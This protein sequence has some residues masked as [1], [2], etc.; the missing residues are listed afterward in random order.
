M[1]GKNP[2]L[3]D[4]DNGNLKMQTDFRQVYAAL[5]TD[6]L[7]ADSTAEA[8]TLFRDFPEAPIFRSTQT[9]TV[10][11]EAASSVRLYPNP[12]SAD[13]ILESDVSLRNT[14]SI[15]LADMQGRQMT[16]RTAQPTANSIL[17]NV[18]HLPT[19]IYVLQLQTD[20]GTFTKRL[21]VSR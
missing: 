19:G 14:Q 20:Q 12:A 7:G 13:V 8:K 4:L 21:L 1:V 18:S 3:T 17:F 11:E 2:S 10:T 9:V 6:W 16:L 15:L 5:L